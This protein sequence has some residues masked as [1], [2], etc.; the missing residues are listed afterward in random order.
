MFIVHRGL[1]HRGHGIDLK[2]EK[3]REGERERERERDEEK[4]K[5]QV[6]V[7]KRTAFKKLGNVMDMI[8]S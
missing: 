8:F 1:V 6:V 3:E 7:K 4:E 2:R 5:S